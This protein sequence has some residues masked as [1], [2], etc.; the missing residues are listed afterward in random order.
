VKQRLRASQGAPILLGALLAILLL[1][2]VLADRALV[3]QA[4]AARAAAVDQADEIAR[5]TASSIRAALSEIEQAVAAG[6]PT[7]ASL[8]ER[9]ALPPQLS[10][11][12]A[13]VDSYAG[14]S[15]A[16]LSR[17]LSS[18][19]AT[20]NGLPEAVVARLLL[21]ETPPVSGTEHPPDVTEMLLSGRLPVRP[22]DLPYLAARLGASRDSRVRTLQ[23][24]LR[25]IPPA[26]EIPTL[27]AFRRRLVDIEAVEGWGRSASTA[28]RYRTSVESLL[29]KAATG[30]RTVLASPA[31]RESFLRG[32]TASSDELTR[33]VQVPDVERFVLSVTPEVPGALRLVALR[34]VLLLCIVAG[35]FGLVAARRAFDRESHA[36]ARERAFL[37]SV[38]HELRTPLAAIRLLGERLADGRGDSR[39]YGS[40]VAHESQRLEDLVERVLSATRVE[41]AP[42]F[43]PASPGDIARSAA[44]LIALR[45]ERRGVAIELRAEEDLP[46]A[47]WDGDAVRSAVLNLLD[48]AVKHGKE[49]GHVVLKVWATGGQIRLAVSDDGPGISRSDRD[50]IFKRFV[51][52]ATSAPGTGLGLHIVEQAARAHGGRVDLDTAEAQGATFTLILPVIPPGAE[53]TI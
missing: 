7:V 4:R 38:T 42:R 9:L 44:N 2:S 30:A 27:P 5:L 35:V 8:I 6:Q 21:G 11:P 18:A 28:V 23:E 20:P 49:G 51:R 15:R 53:V 19:D 24:R 22:D 1:F 14:R 25:L 34:I 33:I 32:A 46:E 37:A 3:S 16:D 13:T 17:L 41:N 10:L 12:V 31:D 39:D 50:G 36:V 40:L 29:R 45:A 52:G 48:N 47:R 43:A 26:S